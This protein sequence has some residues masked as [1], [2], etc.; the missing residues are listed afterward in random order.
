M[1]TRKISRTLCFINNNDNNKISNSQS[2]HITN[3]KQFK[4]ANLQP[5]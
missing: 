4:W 1:Q 5:K 3:V 2:E